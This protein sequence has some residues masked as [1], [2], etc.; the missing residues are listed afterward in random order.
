MGDSGTSA[1][2]AVVLVRPQEEGNIGAAARAMANMGLSELVL[3]AGRASIGSVARAFA[4]GAG[5]LLDAAVV[6]PDLATALAPFQRVVGTTSTRG[7][8]LEVQPIAPRELPAVLAADPPGTR[9]ALVFGPEASGLTADELAPCAPWVHVPCAPEQP[10][11]N[12]AQAVLVVAYEVQLAGHVPGTG[13]DGHP[14]ARRAEVEALL[15]D[16]RPLLAEVG[17]DR[18]G[19]FETVMRD[20]QALAA[21][22]ALTEREVAILRGMC[23]RS[24]STLDRLSEAASGPVGRRSRP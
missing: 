9:T 17:F 10:T 22:A 16:L 13:A 2:L 11:L 7:R 4:V 5:H 21:R 1:R 19:S 8:A 18:D 24:R 3:V 23:R 12:L 20:L 14:L 6:V 15:Q